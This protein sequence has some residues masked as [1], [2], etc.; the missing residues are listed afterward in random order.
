M[1][2]HELAKELG[3]NSKELLEK[4]KGLHFPLKSHMS[5]IDTE[6]VEIIKHELVAQEE[7]K[8][9]ENVL[10]VNFPLTVKDLAVKLSRKPSEL[11]QHLLKMGRM[12]NIN[13]NL[14]QD[15][16]VQL[17]RIFKINLKQKRSKEEELLSVPVGQLRSRPPVV[18]LMG[19]IDHGKTSLLDR[20]RSSN[21]AEKESGGIT[22][23][24]GAY[25]IA[26][27]KGKITFIDTPGHETFTAM[28]ARGANI[29][30]IVI[31]VVAADEGVKPQTEEAIDH[32]R[33]A[34]TP[35][36][37]ALNKI[38]KPN[39]DVARVKEQLHRLN[40]TPEDWG[41]KTITVEVSAKTGKGIDHLIEMI[42]LETEMLELKADYQRSAVGMVVESRLSAGRGPT[43][44]VLIEQGIL[45]LQDIA[46]A[47]IYFGKVRMLY[48]DRG[49]LIK[50]A[51]P[52]TPVE[53]VG[54]DGVPSPGDK[55]LVVDSEKTAREITEKRREKKERE[56]IVPPK[57]ITLEDLYAKI[58]AHEL[59]A[60]RIILKSDVGGTL[61][62]IE[63][64]L[65]KFK[66]E[67]VD[68]EIIHRGV[69]I[70]NTSDVVLAEASDA[71][72]VGFRVPIDAK[73]KELARVKGIDV[74]FYQVVYELINEVKAALEGMLS[75]E[76]KRV[77]V[78]RA[79]VKKVFNLSKS[80]IVAGCM[81]EQGKIV[82]NALCEVSRNNEGIF[83]GKINALKRFK[84]EAKEVTAGMECGI[85]TGYGQIQENDVIDVFIEQKTAKRL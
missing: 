42:L 85:N 79:L 60:L 11:L 44:V 35:I 31:L 43:S 20:I 74:K 57:H 3:I 8:I 6:S 64:S 16:S 65:K 39:V 63:E 29:T 5:V 45:R 51:P 56:K 25:Q 66:S 80:G 30:D 17:A 73:A 68:V 13:Q 19:H 53:I 78:G 75:P 15:T 23:H 12:M 22:Q 24:I 70:V 14:D 81:V 55:L 59:K 40:L 47:D 18:T 27:P 52:A 71:L 4:L 69:G 32:A 49:N 54:L 67:E 28:R 72:V 82:R 10:G 84:E 58:K 83:K 48:D 7:K 38:D 76:I 2:V 41:G 46:V 26:T 62:A 61:E 1:R 33:A 37:V 21:I 50:E 9:E 77:F 36:I 34:K